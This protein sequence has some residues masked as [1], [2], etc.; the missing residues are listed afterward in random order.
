MWKGGFIFMSTNIEVHLN[1]IFSYIESASL[2]GLTEEYKDYIIKSFM[3]YQKKL[4][5][6]YIPKDYKFEDDEKSSRKY[7]RAYLTVSDVILAKNAIER[8]KKAREGIDS[9]NYCKKHFRGEQSKIIKFF[10]QILKANDDNVNADLSKLN[11]K[12]T[13]RIETVTSF[14]NKDNL[15]KIKD[16]TATISINIKR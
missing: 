8:K 6:H 4:N 7:Q 3:S 1:D 9:I 5:D 13:D 15:G 10:K 14:L 12:I 16:C 2:Y 11:L